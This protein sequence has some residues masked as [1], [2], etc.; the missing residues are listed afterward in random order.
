MHRALASL[1]SCNV[2]VSDVCCG[3]KPK[4]ILSHQCVLPGSLWGLFASSTTSDHLTP[5]RSI[6]HMRPCSHAGQYCWQGLSPKFSHRFQSCLTVSWLPAAY[7][8]PAVLLAAVKAV[9]S[10]YRIHNADI[11]MREDC[12]ID[13]LVDVIEGS[14]IYIPAIYVINKIDQITLEELEVGDQMLVAGHPIEL[15]VVLALSMEWP[16]AVH[17]V[18]LMCLGVA[19][20]C[21]SCWKG[22][23]ACIL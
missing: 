18:L 11:H 5:T 22:I 17:V 1:A 2:L 3:C 6:L 19:S 23:R 16:M 13:E 21:S 20:I 4:H 12:D 14:R 7:G 15:Q 10:E 9:C 8:T